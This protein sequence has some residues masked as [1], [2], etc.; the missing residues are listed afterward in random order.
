VGELQ[1][2]PVHETF[3]AWRVNATSEEFQENVK[4]VVAESGQS[5][6]LPPTDAMIRE[7]GRRTFIREAMGR[8]HTPLNQ[9]WSF[10]C[11]CGASA[12]IQADLTLTGEL[13]HGECRS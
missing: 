12:T 2:L 11:T 6:H 5:S 4:R 13:A 3:G 7:A 8:G 1:V 10:E 9:G